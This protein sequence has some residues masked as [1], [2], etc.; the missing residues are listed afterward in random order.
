MLKPAPGLPVTCTGRGAGNK[1]CS[2]A[3][4]TATQS[5]SSLD[6]IVGHGRLTHCRT[7]DSR[8]DPSCRPGVNCTCTRSAPASAA[9]NVTIRLAQVRG[10][11]SPPWRGPAPA[12][13]ESS[14]SYRASGGGLTGCP[15]RMQQIGGLELVGDAPASAR[16]RGG[17]QARA[18]GAADLAA[19][20]GHPRAG[21]FRRPI[22]RCR[23]RS[24]GG[25]RAVRPPASPRTSAGRP[26]RGRNAVAD[27]PS[28]PSRYGKRG[29]QV[30]RWL[31]RRLAKTNP[32]CSSTARGAQAL[33]CPSRGGGVCPASLRGSPRPPTAG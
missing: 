14:G 33:A 24:A 7:R 13:P 27:A 8:A 21:R 32:R 10:V 31:E 2:H 26:C 20:T 3:Y 18:F 5:K 28:A 17:G 9:F 6:G 11:G 1:A 29:Q 22:L 23:G 12:P 4:L 25:S 15:R 30:R 19:R 16:Q